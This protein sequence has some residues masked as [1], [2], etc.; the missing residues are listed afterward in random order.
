[1][2]IFMLYTGGLPAYRQRCN[3]AAAEGYSG[4]TLKARA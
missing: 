3:E 2:R 1:M 4:F